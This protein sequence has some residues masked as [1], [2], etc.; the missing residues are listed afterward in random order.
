MTE[1]KEKITRQDLEAEFQSL[2]SEGQGSVADMG[3]KAAGVAGAF[4]FLAL[5]LTYVLGRR[6]GSKAKATVQIRRI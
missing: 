1:A 4:A 6:R 5:A 2:M 3:R